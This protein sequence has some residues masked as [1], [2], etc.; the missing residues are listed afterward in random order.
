[1]SKASTHQLVT[2]L[3]ATQISRFVFMLRRWL[4]TFAYVCL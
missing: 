3:G 1:M 4:M 2:I